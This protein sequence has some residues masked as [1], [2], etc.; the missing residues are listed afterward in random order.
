MT[1]DI[2]GR[3]LHNCILQKKKSCSLV[4]GLRMG[5]EGMGRGI[6]GA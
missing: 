1:F 3:K 4:T 6:A 2:M 5:T